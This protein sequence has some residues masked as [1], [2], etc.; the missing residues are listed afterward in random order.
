MRLRSALYV[1]AVNARALD[2]ARTLPCDAVILDLE[3]AVAPERKPEARDAAVAALHAGFPGRMAVL[4]V[5]GLDTDWGRTDLL[6]AVRAAPDAVLAPKV[7]DARTLRAYHQALAAAPET[8][9]LWIMVETPRAL[10]NLP[11]IAACAGETR[12]AGLVLGLNDLAAATRARMVP[13]R[14][15]FAAA[16]S[17]VVTAARAHGLLAL[18]A[19]FNDLRDSEGLEAECR[20]GRDWGFDGKTLIHPDQIDAAN[21]AFAPTEAEV[22]WAR[23]VTDAF[24]AEPD[25]G[26]LR[27]AGGMVE[28]LH[29]REAERILSLLE[30]R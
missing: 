13:G 8:V 10:L 21:R 4:R 6:A 30:P 9:R 11:E 28:R 17:A 5:N 3:D 23:A 25:A 27:A 2:K 12:L 22:V 15:P 20:Q 24:A 18:D 1:P 14:A 16:M 26:V 7:E 29:L 19:V